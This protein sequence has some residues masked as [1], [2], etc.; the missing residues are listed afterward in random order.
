[1]K[2][3]LW[4]VLLV[5]SICGVAGNATDPAGNAFGV[6]LFAAIA[7]FAIR[8]LIAPAHPAPAR[9]AKP[10]GKRDADA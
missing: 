4:A 8:Q 10:K 7:S 6:V 9:H 3:T 2:R 1:M 5:F